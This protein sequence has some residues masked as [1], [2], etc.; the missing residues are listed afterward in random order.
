MKNY[1]VLDEKLFSVYQER[2][3][4]YTEVRALFE[5]EWSRGVLPFDEIEALNDESG[6][7]LKKSDDVLEHLMRLSDDKESTEFL[8]ALRAKYEPASQRVSTYVLK[9]PRALV[10]QHS[11]PNLSRHFSSNAPPASLKALS[12]AALVST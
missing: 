9:V 7:L 5:Y 3:H 4:A 6:D 10:A 1:D 8:I 11:P 2:A 12:E